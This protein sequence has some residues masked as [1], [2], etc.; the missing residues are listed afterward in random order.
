MSHVIHRV[1]LRQQLFYSDTDYV[2]FEALI[3][4][5]HQQIP[6][7]IDTDELIPNQSN[8]MSFKRGW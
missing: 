7:P 6:L 4:E 1:A 8:A 2:K 5:T 3:E